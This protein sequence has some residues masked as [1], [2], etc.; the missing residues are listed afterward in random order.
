MP[1]DLHIHTTFSDGRNT[2]EEIMEAAKAAGLR[3]ISITDHDSVEGVTELYESGHISSGS[4]RVIPGVGFSTGDGGHDVHILG[5]NI[6]IYDAGLQEKLEEIS[7]ARWTR[8]TKIVELL[9]GLGY[10]IGETEVLTDEGMCKAIGRSHVARVLVKKGYFDSVRACFD[11][12]LKR[13]Q[14][15]YVP[16][17]RVS[18]EEL[19]S[20]IRGAGGI[21][22]LANPKSVGDETIIMT[23]VG[24]GLQGVEAFY[25]TYDR[26]DT[27]HYLDVAQK[28]GLLVSGGSDYRGFP[29]RG[30]EKIGQFTIEDVYAENF[31]RPPQHT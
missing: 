7:E 2:P 20:L 4:L 24:Q 28:Y 11:Q 16:H 25:P 26:Q 23:L 12:L 13:G 19:I 31:Y 17:F 5:Y 22:V 29:G 6:D 30:T 9:R 10:E 3:Y 27:Q 14:P 18:A 21:P 15:A 1:S 8:F